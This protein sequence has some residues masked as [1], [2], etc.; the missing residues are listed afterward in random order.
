MEVRE[1]QHLH[2]MEFCMATAATPYKL[3][4]HQV[5]EHTVCLQQMAVSPTWGSCGAGSGNYI[6]NQFSAQQTSSNFWISGTGRADTSFSTILL[7]APTAV[8]LNV[9]TTNATQI[10]LKKNTDVTG[11]IN[12]SQYYSIG[13]SKVLDIE[14]TGTLLVGVGAGT[15]I[16]AGA[17]E[18]VLIGNNRAIQLTIQMLIITWGLVATP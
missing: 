15:N 10:N 1:L 12:T 16:V 18:N 5:Q 11:T 7:D 14:N 13:S 9:G 6:D 3:Q 2:L 4:P 8:A 17:N